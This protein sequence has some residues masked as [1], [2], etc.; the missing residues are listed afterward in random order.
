MYYTKMCLVGPNRLSGRKA[1]LD[2]DRIILP[3]LV[4]II[5]HLKKGKIPLC[6]Y[7]FLIMSQY[8]DI[9]FWYPIYFCASARVTYVWIFQRWGG[10]SAYTHCRLS[11]WHRHY[12]IHAHPIKLYVPHTSVMINEH[13]ILIKTW[14]LHCVCLDNNSTTPRLLHSHEAV[15]Q[16][17]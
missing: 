2:P 15:F 6:T 12:Y 5:S 10:R 9:S 4:P 7:D 3:T 14:H 16:S 1:T 8:T 11:S 13:L 17:M